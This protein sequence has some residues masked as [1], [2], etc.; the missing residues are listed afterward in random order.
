VRRLPPLSA[1]RAFEA[2]AR[3]GSVTRAAAE[4]GRTHGAVSRQIRSLQDQAGFALFDKAGTGLQL[5]PSGQALLKVVAAALDGLERGWDRVLDEARGPAVH[6]ACSAT[7]AM[8]WLVPRL[9]AFYRAHP[10][11]RLRLSMTT[12]REL[13]HEGADLVIAWDRSSYPAGDLAGAVHLGA[14]AFGPVCAPGYKMTTDGT[15]L[16]FP[17]R[18]AHE[19]TS[20]AWTLWQAQSGRSVGFREELRFPHTHLCIEAALTG[21][22]VAL[23]E[24]RL[25]QDELASGRLQAP[26]GFVDFGVGLA[27]VPTSERATSPAA[28]AFIAWLGATLAADV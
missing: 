17:V 25:V 14:V 22:G 9:S 10:A 19:Y 18:V 8:R 4:L 11:I 2:T 3:L 13:R 15:D 12:A 24:R 16:A 27:A 7:F 1:L 6:V 23:V 28:H 5:N 20:R 21:L 26:C